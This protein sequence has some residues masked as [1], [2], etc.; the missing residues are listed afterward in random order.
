[1]E[2]TITPLQTIIKPHSASPNVLESVAGEPAKSARAHCTGKPS[3]FGRGRPSIYLIA[4]NDA[5]KAVIWPLHVETP[6]ISLP[7]EDRLDLNSVML[8][9]TSEDRPPQGPPPD[10]PSW[11]L[12][13]LLFGV[14]VRLGLGVLIVSA[15]RSP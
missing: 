5:K 13:G 2:R 7:E 9:D 8:N 14:I 11:A 15:P 4:V 1:M 6:Q 10:C 12:I 3:A